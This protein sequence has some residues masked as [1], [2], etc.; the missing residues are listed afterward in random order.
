M[1]KEINR[2]L[3]LKVRSEAGHESPNAGKWFCFDDNSVDAW[4][5]KNLDK[6]CFGGKYN[7]DMPD[8]GMGGTKVRMPSII[9]PYIMNV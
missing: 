2:A 1:F 3:A 7:L 4:D 6:D 8:S 5:I 9:H